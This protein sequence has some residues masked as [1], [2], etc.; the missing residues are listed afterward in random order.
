MLD[1]IRRLL[2]TLDTPRTGQM[3]VDDPRVAAAALLVHVAEADGAFT[4]AE[5]ARL[6]ALLQREFGIEEREAV[7]LLEEGRRA[8]ADAI[9]LFGFTSILMN[10]MDTERRL[11]FVDLLWSLIYADGDVHELED[12][13]AWRICELLGISTEDRMAAKRA[14]ARRAGLAGASV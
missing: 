5:S 4:P 8:D 3:R 11:A 6:R 9:D 12:N 13:L 10:G 1:Q 2:R 7:A 14:A